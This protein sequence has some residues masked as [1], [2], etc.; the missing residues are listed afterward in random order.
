MSMYP[1]TICSNP[2][3]MAYVHLNDDSGVPPRPKWKACQGTLQ[4]R[5]GIPRA[6]HWSA[7]G[8]TVSGLPALMI[9]STL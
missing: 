9:M 8:L 1:P 7:D 6:S 5:L 3:A 2:R 4:E